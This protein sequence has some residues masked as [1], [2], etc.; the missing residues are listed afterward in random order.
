MKISQMSPF[1]QLFDGNTPTAYLPYL[2]MKNEVKTNRDPIKKGLHNF[3][4]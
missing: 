3:C 2:G 1:L 4:S